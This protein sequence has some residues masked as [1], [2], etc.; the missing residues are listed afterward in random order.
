MSN[1]V[2]VSPSPTKS[3]FFRAILKSSTAIVSAIGLLKSEIRV[4]LCPNIFAVSSSTPL[5]ISWSFAIFAC[6]SL[7]KFS[8]VSKN[9]LAFLSL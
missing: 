5:F 2:P 7:I 4:E 9:S 1:P 3:P 6:S 8:S